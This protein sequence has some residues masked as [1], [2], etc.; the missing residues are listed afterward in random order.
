MNTKIQELTDLIY[1]EGVVKGQQEADKVISEAQAKADK[2]LLDARKEA[3]AIIDM[4]NENAYV[5]DNK[6]YEDKTICYCWKGEIMTRKYNE[7]SNK[8]ISD[9]TIKD[10]VYLNAC[11]C[12]YYGYGYNQLNKC[13]LG[14]FVAKMIWKQ[15]IAD[16]GNDE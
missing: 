8:R 13:G 10:M 6:I 11:E 5:E 15:A 16:L 12:L 2:I 3:D 7:L 1:N 9:L 4:F 14:D